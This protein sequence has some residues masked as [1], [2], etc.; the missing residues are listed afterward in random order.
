MKKKDG[1]ITYRLIQQRDSSGDQPA[2]LLPAT[3]IIKRIYSDAAV[4]KFYNEFMAM[5]SFAS[6]CLDSSIDSPSLISSRTSGF[7]SGNL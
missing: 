3:T 5:S 1:N 6:M 4:G 2:S 7:S